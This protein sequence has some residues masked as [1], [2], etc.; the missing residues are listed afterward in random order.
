MKTYIS[1]GSTCSVA[2]QLDKHNLR[3]NAYPFDWL[4]CTSLK[5]I[6][7]CIQE[8]FKDFLDVIKIRESDKHPILTTDTFNDSSNDISMVM[9]NTYDME[10]YHDF[11][12]N[13]NLDDIKEKYDRRIKRFID[14]IN[15]GNEIIFV[16][17]ELKINSI[18]QEDIDEFIQII[19]S[20][21]PNCNF[22]I[23]YI[24]YNPKNKKI[25]FNNIYIINDTK[26]FEHW[27]R[28]NVEWIKLLDY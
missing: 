9:R 13:S 8:N 1:L 14:I 26:N 25:N 19:K 24:V 17:D 21:N 5:M 3:V 18:K 23:V 11:S 10:F 15:S 22:K 7:K 6:T 20:I 27:Q 28:P 16:R 12:A 2:Y 4:K